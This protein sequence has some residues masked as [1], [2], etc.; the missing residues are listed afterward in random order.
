MNIHDRFEQYFPAVRDAFLVYDLDP[1][2]A[3]GIAHHETLWS[4]GAHSPPGASDDRL[5]GAYGLFQMTVNTAEDLGFIG[6]PS[7]LYEPAFNAS[8]AAKLM[9]R[10]KKLL[11]GLASVDNLIAAHN[12]GAGHVLKNTIP[13]STKTQ[14]VPGVKAAMTLWATAVAQLSK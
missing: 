6:D 11:G 7:R 3:A 1:L 12:C 4:P 9:S 14:Y 13:A 5:G 8:L 2:V 10:N